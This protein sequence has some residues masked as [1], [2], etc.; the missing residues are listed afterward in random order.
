MGWGV[1][2]NGLEVLYALGRGAIGVWIAAFEW[3]EVSQSMRVVAYAYFTMGLPIIL[4]ALTMRLLA[5]PTTVGVNR[6]MV[7]TQVL[8]AFLIL[9][10]PL[11]IL[12]KYAAVYLRGTYAT[13]A[14]YKLAGLLVA[15]ALLLGSLARL[16]RHAPTLVPLIEV[17]RDLVFGRIRPEEAL[18]RLESTIVGKTGADLV[19]EAMEPLRAES[20]AYKRAMR[21]ADVLAA[22]YRAEAGGPGVVPDDEVN[23]WWRRDVRRWRREQKRLGWYLKWL[24]LRLRF[25]TAGD[26]SADEVATK[27]LKRLAEDG[28]GRA[29]LFVALMDRR[30]AL[31]GKTRPTETAPP[32]KDST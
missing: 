31:L 11:V 7:R 2:L 30:F 3:P 1:P 5:F 8:F 9:L 14:D 10:L 16:Y 15:S 19:M 25:L 22:K 6:A 12:S 18:R 29:K 20:K 13:V 4:L 26:P 21:T 17:R 23:K 27:E 28:F 24:V 32:D